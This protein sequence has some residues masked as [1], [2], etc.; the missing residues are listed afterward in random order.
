MTIISE[1]LKIRGLV[2][3]PGYSQFAPRALEHDFW[4]LGHH[5]RYGTFKKRICSWSE[6]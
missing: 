5:Y 4:Y 2:D 1:L 3:V 6:K